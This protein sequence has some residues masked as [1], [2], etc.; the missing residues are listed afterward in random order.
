MDAG[1][2][3]TGPLD[4]PGHCVL[5]VWSD[6]RGWQATVQ[7]GEETPRTFHEPDDALLFLY[8]CLLGRQEAA[9]TA[10]NSSAPDPG[11]LP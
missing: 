7:R 5:R 10:L 6:A 2:P 8:S 1:E 9:P 4:G 3:P 11:R